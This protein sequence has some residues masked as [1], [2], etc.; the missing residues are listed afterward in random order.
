MTDMGHLNESAEL[1]YGPQIIR[2]PSYA[3]IT[4]R[5]GEVDLATEGDAPRSR[6]S[7]VTNMSAYSAR[8][9]SGDV[10]YFRLDCRSDKGLRWQ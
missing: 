7:V 4:G 3:N 1:A 2:E 6:I 9:E 5:E 10:R 8:I